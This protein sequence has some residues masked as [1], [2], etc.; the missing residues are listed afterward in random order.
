MSCEA[1][2][3][4]EAETLNALPLLGVEG[5]GVMGAEVGV[6][7]AEAT[8]RVG[9]E[10]GT[11]VSPEEEE[12]VGVVGVVAAVLTLAPLVLRLLLL[13]LLSEGDVLTLVL[14]CSGE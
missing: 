4:D 7:G 1:R 10:G 3:V 2:G 12:E 13:L 5:V 8:V 9:V 14:F 11:M 6:M